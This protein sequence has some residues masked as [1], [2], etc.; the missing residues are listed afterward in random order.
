MI[1]ILKKFKNLATLLIAFAIY[2]MTASLGLLAASINNQASPVWPATGIAI[3]LLLF[4]EIKFAIAGIFLAAFL[5][6]FQTGLNPLASL[7]IAM[8]NS[9]EAVFFVWVFGRYVQT[10]LNQSPH[11]KF[12]VAVASLMGAAA[13]SAL[14]GTLALYTTSIISG[15]LIVKNWITWWVGDLLGGLFIIPIAY[16]IKNSGWVVFKLHFKELAKVI[17]YFTLVGGVTYWLFKY[18]FASP[19][20][21]ILFPILLL[22]AESLDVIWLYLSGVLICVCA[23]TQTFAGSGPFIGGTLNESLILLQI[24][25]AGLILTAIGVSSLKQIQ[26]GWAPKLALLFGWLFSGFTFY[27]S[28]SASAIS[29]ENIYKQKILLART[30]IDQQFS[31][32]LSMLDSAAGLLNSSDFV[33]KKEWKIFANRLLS[34]N[35]LPGVEGVGVIYSSTIKDRLP[36]LKRPLFESNAVNKVHRVLNL[37]TADTVEHPADNFIIYYLEPEKHNK[38]AIGLNISSERKRFAA[39]IKARDSGTAAMT[40]EI[41]LVQDNISRPGFLLYVPVYLTGKPVDTIENRRKNFV[42]FVYTPIVYANFLNSAVGSFEKHLM[43]RIFV[44]KEDNSD[45]EVYSSKLLEDNK[46]KFDAEPTAEIINLAGEKLKLIITPALGFE[47]TKSLVSSWI[48]FFGAM[49]SLSLAI[50]LSSIQNLALHAQRIAEVMNKE[51]KQ[52]KQT[53]RTLT[54]TSPFGIYIVDANGKCSYVNPSW[55]KMSGVTEAQALKS[56]DGIVHPDDREFVAEQWKNLIAGG[57]FKCE[58]RYLKADGQVVNISGEAVPLVDENKS[59]T[60]YFGIV[61]DITELNKNQMA[62][63]SASRM[64]SLGLMAAGIAHEINN[65]LTIVMGKAMWLEKNLSGASPMSY[66]DI[67][68]NISHISQTSQKIAK[69]VNGLRFFSRDSAHDQTEF[70]SIQKCISETFSLCQKRFE[71]HQTELT[72]LCKTQDELFVNGHAGQL[73]QVLLNL[74]SNAFDA[75]Q[76][77][78]RRWVHVDLK[79]DDLKVYIYVTDSGKRITAEL[80]SKIFD[81]FF[82]TKAVGK[83]TGLGLSISKGIVEN[84]NGRI[85]VNADLEHTTFVIE[86][87]RSVSI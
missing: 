28:Y 44:L 66:E 50:M 63:I 34:Q 61:Q 15:D 32:Y 85:Y 22:I 41:Q 56:L 52:Q 1:E 35:Q 62:L 47:N 37:S 33:S 57:V 4:F 55:C 2:Y 24:F 23:I 6:N 87:P 31:N 43:F 53:W 13:T 84:H 60:G 79:Y 54:E 40:D 3:T 45:L 5:A 51:L 80:A 71:N 20:L 81:P 11:V 21:F 76:S 12:V 73:S 14:F 9:I 70:F 82:T 29:D 42:G 39:A 30:Q 77:V 38:K 18:E 48:S 78:E 19:Y 65:P 64:S 46:L 83:G 36:E 7:I 69:I 16:R 25:L 59:V 10:G 86:L 17:F 67:R 74:L 8:G 58:Y 68:E 75:V 49:L 72:F 26:F 27:Y